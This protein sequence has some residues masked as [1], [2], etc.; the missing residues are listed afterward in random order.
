M[1]ELINIFLGTLDGI[2]IMALIYKSF[3][4][5]FW[6]SFSKIF[7]I[8]LLL[9]AVSYLD[10][11]IIGIEMY[12]MFVQLILYVIFL[13]YIIRVNI[14]CAYPLAVYGYIF[15]LAIQFATYALLMSAGIVSESDAANADGWGTYIIQFSS[16]IVCFIVATLAYLFNL[17]FSYIDRPPH[18]SHIIVRRGKMDL[19]ATIFGTIVV[20]TFMYWIINCQLHVYIIL[21]ALVLSM[22]I[23]LY[24]AKRKDVE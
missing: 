21:P 4:W 2:A 3:R 24:L 17:G 6:E 7:V 8:A 12:D 18:D 15:F 1:N 19:A 22:T 13:R 16:E 23:L 11:V 9:A 14:L 5:P 10:R 20:I